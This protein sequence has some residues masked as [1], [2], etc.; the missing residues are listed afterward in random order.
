MFTYFNFLFMK[1]VSNRLIVK[2][3]KSHYIEFVKYYSLF[4]VIIFNTFLMLS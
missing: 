4:I 2:D 3:F 1:L